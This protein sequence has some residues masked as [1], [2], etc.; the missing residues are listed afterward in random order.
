[1]IVVT[2]MVISIVLIFATAIIVFVYTK[3][4]AS[5]MYYIAMYYIP[6]LLL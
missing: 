6:S 3:N 1:M 4:S 2:N 5:N